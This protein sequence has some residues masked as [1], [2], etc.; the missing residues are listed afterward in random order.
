[1]KRHCWLIALS[2]RTKR[3]LA[4]RCHTVALPFRFLLHM[5]RKPRNVKVV[6]QLDSIERFPSSTSDFLL[7]QAYP[8]ATTKFPHVILRRDLSTVTPLRS[9]LAV[10][11]R[12]YHPAL[13][14]HW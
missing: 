12:T 1:M 4:V 2:V 13:S 10:Q 7:S 11:R 6:G 8:G 3:S 14:V 9:A 5:W